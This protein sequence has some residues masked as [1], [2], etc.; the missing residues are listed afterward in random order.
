MRTIKTKRVRLVLPAILIAAILSACGS[1]GKDTEQAGPRVD[2]N[3]PAELS[4]YAA[5]A[6]FTE[7]IFQA[8]IAE[9]IRK[10]FPHY[11]INYVK[12]GSVKIADMIATNNVPDIFL[13]ALPEMQEHLL[14][15]GLQYDMTELIKL[16]G[17]DL[18][19]FD[20]AIVQ[21]IR[22]ASGEGRLYGLPESVSSDMMFYNKDIFDKFG[23]P[24]PRDGMTWDEAYQMSR[25]LTNFSEGVQY[26]GVT[27]FFRTVLTNNSDS[28]P[29]IDPKTERAVVNADGWK[30]QFDNLKRFYE[31]TGMTA[32]FKPGGDGNSE[33]VSFYTD[34]NVAVVVSP[35]TAYTR[36]GFSDLNWDMAAAPTFADRQGV[37]FQVGP[38]ALFISNTST[39]KEQAFQVI[40]HLLSDEV[41]LQN[42]KLGQITSLNNETVRKTFGSDVQALKGKNVA[43]VFHNKIAPTPQLPM[44]STNAG[45]LLGNEF[46]AVIQGKKDVNTALR[47]AE[48]TINKAI[49]EEIAKRRKP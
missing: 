48:E 49:D 13:Y 16:S 33:L 29:L 37:G 20:P 19:R 6:S 1:S 40:A 42:N 46:D 26:R 25:K 12:P 23:V 30:K 9:P 28:L 24:Y 10:K 7:E 34:K 32:G 21:T 39:V 17:Y 4:F 47:S 44:L 35:L 43:S 36:A 41:Q 3:A 45:K 5:S 22:N 2:L 38:R 18:N 8:R 27:L 31:L 15:Y 14:P 11:T